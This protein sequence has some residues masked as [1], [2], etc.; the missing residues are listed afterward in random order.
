MSNIKLIALDLDGT[1]FNSQSRISEENL[2]AIKKATAQGV[3]IVISSGRPYCGLP[4]DQIKGSGIRYAI[5][6]NG[7]AIYDITTDCCIHED[8]MDNSIA[9]PILEY[10][11]SKDILID[12]FTEGKAVSPLKCID[13]AYKLPVP[14]PIKK[15][16]IESRTRVEDLRAYLVEH[17]LQIQKMTLN[18]YPDENGVFV[19]REEVKQY[20]LSNPNVTCVSGGYNNLE[21]TRAGI[22]KGVGLHTLARHLGIDIQ[23]T[24]AIGDTENDISI[25]KAAGIG[26][27]MAN[28]TDEVKAVASD[29]TLSNDENGVAAAI[30][31]YI[32]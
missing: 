29:I 25:L 31:K 32:F 18:F 12:A 7:S 11:L 10:L 1:L 14:E 30:Y 19:D 20:L 6:T 23:D 4:F 13:V 21:F 3:H 26:I 15:F 9:F 24:I 17:Q 5:T 28:A 27:A 8:C 2:A 22:D 16:I